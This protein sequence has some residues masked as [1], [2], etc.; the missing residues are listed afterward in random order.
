MPILSC[1]PC[2]RDDECG[3]FGHCYFDEE[4]S[5]QGLCLQLCERDDNCVSGQECR[6]LSVMRYCLEPSGSYLCDSN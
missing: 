1:S 5:A 4:V 3:A 2:Q 6:Q